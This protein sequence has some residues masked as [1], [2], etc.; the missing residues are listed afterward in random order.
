MVDRAYWQIGVITET[1][2]RSS[3]CLTETPRLRRSEA[4]W[5]YWWQWWWWWYSWWWW[6]RF[7]VSL[8]SSRPQTGRTTTHWTQIDRRSLRHFITVH[9]H[10]NHH[11]IS[12][13]SSSNSSTRLI[14]KYNWRQFRQLMDVTIL[15]LLTAPASVALY[16]TLYM[17]C[18]N[19]S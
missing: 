12:S 6:W 17:L 9:H 1:T 7:V 10:D 14:A 2:Y 19:N 8:I 4:K 18:I 11:H 13:S 15:W 16:S 5:W 3:E